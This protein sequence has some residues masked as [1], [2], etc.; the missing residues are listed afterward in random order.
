MPKP[1]PE[2]G[3]P[4]LVRID[5][6][7]HQVTEFISQA[8]AARQLDVSRAT[9]NFLVSKGRLRSANIAGRNV[10][11]VEDVLAYTPIRPGPKKGSVAAT[12]KAS[13]KKG[14]KK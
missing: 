9:V 1:K 7:N 12:R 4:V 3:I 14:V 13:K 11:M 6:E 10:V 8:E 2:A 5:F